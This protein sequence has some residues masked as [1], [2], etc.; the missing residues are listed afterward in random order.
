MTKV[1]AAG[2]TAPSAHHHK[3]EKVMRTRLINRNLLTP[4]LLVL[5][6][7]AAGSVSGQIHEGALYQITAR[8]SGKCL[9]VDGGVSAFNNGALVVQRECNN[10][11]NQQWTLN[12][13]DGANVYKITAKH[14][15]KVLDVFGGVFSGADQVIVEQWDWNR[16]QNQMWKIN[17]LGN[18]FFSI[19]AM[20]SGKALDIRG[21][22]RDDGAQAQQYTFAYG[23]NQEWMLTEI[24]VCASDDSLISTFT[25]RAE[26]RTT[27]PNAP[28]P[29]FASIRLSTKFSE[30]RTAL[31]I[32]DFAPVRVSFNTPLGPNTLSL[33]VAEQG[34]GSFNSSTGRIA[35]PVTFNLSNTI[36]FFGNSRL[37]LVLATQDVGDM[38]SRT[39]GRATVRG[40]GTFVG[41]A[42]NGFQATLVL[43]G[44][45]SPIPR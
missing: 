33:T 34:I 36:L 43:T 37:P 5:L 12:S 3:G 39:T 44:T 24:P 42:L 6:F 29:F 32:S 30:C 10:L 4:I 8:H 1:S 20:H 9:E 16:S 35:I 26:L 21:A 22:L 41:G 15:N 11:S 40:T 38:V 31:T 25:G 2:S 19:I 45:F 13:V 23:A 7:V 28:G 14:S 17:P 18:G 27:H